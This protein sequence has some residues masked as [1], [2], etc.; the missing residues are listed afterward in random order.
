MKNFLQLLFTITGAIALA[1]AI[2]VIY[3]SPIW[4]SSDWA[5]LGLI[6]LLIASSIDQFRK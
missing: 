2:Y 5:I 6:S 4:A 1:R 3:G